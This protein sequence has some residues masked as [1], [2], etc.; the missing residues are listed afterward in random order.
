MKNTIILYHKNCTDGM[1]SAWVCFQKFGNDA[2]YIGCDDWKNLPSYFSSILNLKDLEIY[3]IDFSFT[4]EI[5]LDL[6]KKCKKLVILDHHV[7]AKE[8]IQAVNNHV[9]GVNIS[10]CALAWNYFFPEKEVPLAIQY[11]SDS[12]TG[13]RI[14]PDHKAICS[15]IYR[16][17]KELSVS[18][19]ENVVR[20]LESLSN[21]ENVKKI[22]QMLSD[23]RD[24]SIRRYI[25]KAEI[26]NFEGQDVYA[27]NAPSEIKSDLGR[28]LAIKTNSF[29]IIYNYSE[30][31]W[32]VS[33]RSVPDFDVSSI[34]IKYGGGGHKNAAAFNVTAD[35]PILNIL[36]KGAK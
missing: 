1:A 19:I 35:N 29:A 24:G 7:S 11:I 31:K 20:D 10:G 3:I 23:V 5:L 4:K 34:A 8:N 18:S 14:L 12:D 13:K 33:M 22:G 9:Y 32:G 6:E 30:G 16:D 28:E 21:F 2:E 25:S 15:Y 17:D 27:V 36:Q 26:I